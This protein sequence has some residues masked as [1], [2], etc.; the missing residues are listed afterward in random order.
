MNK[1]WKYIS[2]VLPLACLTALPCPA[3]DWNQDLTK[4]MDS[5]E[6][7]IGSPE[8][9]TQPDNKQPVE[10]NKEEA[11]S[12]QS[13]PLGP[14][15]KTGSDMDS[16]SDRPPTTF[17]Q[18][19]DSRL[20]T[21]ADLPP[22]APG[23]GND[24]LA[25]IDENGLTRWPEERMPVKIHIDKSSTLPGYKDEFADMLKGAFQKWQA[26]LSE[27]LQLEFVETAD[28]AQIHCTWTEDKT[29]LMS[30]KE[31]GNTMLIPDNDGILSVN[32]KILTLPPPG[33]S[34]V[35]FNY[36][37]RVCIHEAGHALGLTGHSNEPDDIMY[38][39]VY[40]E[41]RIA[42]LTDR[43]RD[44][45]VA[46][47]NL[48][49]ATMAA[50][51]IDPTANSQIAA[52]S[53]NPKIKALALNNQAVQCLQNQNIQEAMTLL[54]KAHKLDPQNQLVAKNLG[55]IYANYGS[56]AAMTF[57]MPGACMYLKKA[58]PLLEKS[59]DRQSMIQVIDNYIKIL[60]LTH[61]NAELKLMEKKL[62]G[63]K[64]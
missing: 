62:A 27:K 34:V 1:L 25:S 21:Q 2:S 46:L 47:Y 6:K 9:K 35:P 48:D 16:D 64:K 56:I 38:S 52:N 42:S 4:M 44:T 24:Y 43:D 30:L 51:K 61:D 57:N 31:G 10:K 26:C 39:T 29:E 32:M 60:N 5:V 17:E 33:N 54:E 55:G 59:G 11:P 40:P 3:A 22:E 36:M 23:S 53:K 63:L 13:E 58:I 28:Q 12:G 7:E 49:Q 37:E 8:A 15:G 14:D 50:S 41:E 20:P 45:I 18:A 19:P